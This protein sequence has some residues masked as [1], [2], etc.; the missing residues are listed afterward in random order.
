MISSLQTELS[1]LHRRA[2][3]NKN[4]Q[5]SDIARSAGI[6]VNTVRFYESIG[7]LPAIPRN[8][9][10]GYRTFSQKHVPQ[11][12][13][14]RHLMNVT[15]IGGEIRRHCICAIR[16]SAQE[17]TDEAN[18]HLE[19]A[20]DA[21]KQE[22][23]Y[24]EVAMRILE[25]WAHNGKGKQKKSIGHCGMEVNEVSIKITRTEAA[26]RIGVSPERIRNWERNGLI[27]VP[28]RPNGYREYGLVELERLAV[29]RALLQ[30]GYR[31]MPVRMA[32]RMHDDDAQTD[33]RSVIE[34]YEDDCEIYAHAN[35]LQTAIRE[36]LQNA[37]KARQYL[38]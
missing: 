5:T 6:H 36:C 25:R 24:A 38:R 3:M 7:F 13:L 4:L 14:I 2:Y 16:S 10:N 19:Q 26:K 20:I 29:I 21:I 27:E 9:N 15:W 11:V 1:K 34:N 23:N 28:R 22:M 32:L 30:C 8:R 31:Q 37:L 35:D 18:A 12:L 17:K 33:V